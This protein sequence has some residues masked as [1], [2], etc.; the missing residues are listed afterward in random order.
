MGALNDAQD[1]VRLAAFV[2]VRGPDHALNAAGATRSLV[3]RL[4]RHGQDQVNHGHGRKGHLLGSLVRNDLHVSPRSFR[5]RRYTRGF[6]GVVK[7]GKN[8]GKKG[9]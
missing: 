9:R 5:T 4:G 7:A 2:L 1:L 6:P 3:R 8:V